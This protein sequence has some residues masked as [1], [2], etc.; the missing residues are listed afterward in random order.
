MSRPSVAWRTRAAGLPQACVVVGELHLVRRR[1]DEAL[2]GVSQLQPVPA[3]SVTLEQWS[4]VE[5]AARIASRALRSAIPAATTID[6][7]TETGV[8]CVGQRRVDP[9][10]GRQWF[11]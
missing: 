3:G 4:R 7:K 1:L 5:Q 10:L 11:G 6:E 2:A 9:Q 8:L